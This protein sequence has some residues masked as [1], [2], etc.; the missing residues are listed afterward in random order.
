MTFANRKEM[1]IRRS[2]YVC[3]RTL[4]VHSEAAAIQIPRSMVM[5]LNDPRSIGSLRIE[6]EA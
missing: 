3:G 4:A 1:V 6:V 5:S 2:N